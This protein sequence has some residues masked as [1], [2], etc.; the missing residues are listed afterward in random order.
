[1][2]GGCV[3]EVIPCLKRNEKKVQGE[4]ILARAQTMMVNSGREED[5]YVREH[6]KE[7]P[8][9]MHNKIFVFPGIVITGVYGPHILCTFFQ[10]ETLIG[11]YWPVY[12]EW[13]GGELLFF[14][15]KIVDSVF[16]RP[17]LVHPCGAFFIFKPLL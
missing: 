17:A 9:K 13:G 5:Y 6:Q 8:K 7:I 16:I 14:T 12:S 11:F 10:N 1:M 2:I 4:E 15:K 3:F